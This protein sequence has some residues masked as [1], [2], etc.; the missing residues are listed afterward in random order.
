MKVTSYI[1]IGSN[2][3]DPRK[4][5]KEA[6]KLLKELDSTVVRKTSSLYVTKPEGG[7]P[8]QG[9]YINGVIEVETSLTPGVLLKE[10]QRIEAAL[11][12]QRLVKDGARTIDLDILTYGDSIINDPE[13]VVPHPD[14]GKRA[15][16]LK[17][18][19][20]IAPLVKHPILSKSI[21]ELYEG[22][23]S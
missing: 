20:E 19:S 1:G 12:R 17:G 23:K 7:P 11:K 18:F 3:G 5:I 10:L 13:L 15:F 21:K 8:G 4:N 2:L 16:V 22:I 6:I 14:M 9:D